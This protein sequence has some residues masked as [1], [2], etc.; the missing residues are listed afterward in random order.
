[1]RQSETKSFIM[2]MFNI[3]EQMDEGINCYDFNSVEL[4][5]SFQP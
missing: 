2:L 4:L 1:M 3:L 5:Y